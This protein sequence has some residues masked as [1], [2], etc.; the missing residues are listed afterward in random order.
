VAESSTPANNANVN[1]ITL[2]ILLPWIESIVNSS[3]R[4]PE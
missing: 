2:A 3:E 4:S 1:F